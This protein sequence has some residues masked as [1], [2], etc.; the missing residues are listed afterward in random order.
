MLK[1]SMEWL[2]KNIHRLEPIWLEQN[3]SEQWISLGTQEDIKQV[4]IL[5]EAKPFILTC[6]H[7]LLFTLRP[8]PVKLISK[9]CNQIWKTSSMPMCCEL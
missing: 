8:T 2:V 9:K 6:A 1:N 3:C 5:Q 4:N 7:F